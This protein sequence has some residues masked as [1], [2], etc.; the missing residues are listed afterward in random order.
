[1]LI[2]GLLSSFICIISKRVLGF[3]SLGFNCLLYMSLV[4]IGQQFYSYQWDVLMIEAGFLAIFM[5]P[6]KLKSGK[7]EQDLIGVVVRELQIWLFFRL[8]VSSG[9]GKLLSGD[10]TWWGLSAQKWHFS[11][12]PIPH[13]GSWLHHQLSD[14][15]KRY[16]TA[17]IL[18]FEVNYFRIEFRNSIFLI[19]F[20]L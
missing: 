19:Q 14:G 10:G 12:Q 2:T 9:F 20:C 13:I 18:Y 8:M 16:A 11:S 3:V 15:L 17:A 5:V 1:M 7:Y 4:N 6:K